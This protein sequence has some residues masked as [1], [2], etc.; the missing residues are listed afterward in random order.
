M[1]IAS[2][3]LAFALVG[4]GLLAEDSTLKEEVIQAARKLQ[5]A[6]N[7]SWKSQMESGGGNARLGGPVEGK[8]EKGG[9]TH[10]SFTRA[11][12]TI[13]AVLKGDKSVVKIQDGWHSV[14][15]LPEGDGAGG[16]RNPARMIARMIQSF[17]TPSV[18][19]QDIVS[20]SK[21]LKKAEGSISGELTEEGAKELIVLG[22]RRGGETPTVSHARGSVKFWLKD[23]VLSKCELKVQGSLSINGNDREVDRTTTVEVK[24][25]GSTK[26]EVPDEAKKKF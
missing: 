26:L 19:A 20:K 18:Q 5:D 8:T 2:L 16:S 17:K 7:Y 15:A 6:A 14:D 1:K 21:N 24:D 12:N 23:G 25:I 13:E 22:G 3:I 10:L 9:F 11:E 4:G